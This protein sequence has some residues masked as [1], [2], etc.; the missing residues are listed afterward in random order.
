MCGDSEKSTNSLRGWVFFPVNS[1][2]SCELIILVLKLHI[3]SQRHTSR[4]MECFFL[5][6]IFFFVLCSVLSA[7]TIDTML[8]IHKLTEPIENKFANDANEKK[9]KTPP[10]TQNS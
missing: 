7:T 3:N 2:S 5:C 10:H 9:K 8:N 4:W 6:S 1:F